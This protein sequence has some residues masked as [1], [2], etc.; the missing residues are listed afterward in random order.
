MKDPEHAHVLKSLRRK[1]EEW[2]YQTEDPLALSGRACQLGSFAIIRVI[3][4]N[5][6]S[7]L[8]DRMG[9]DADRPGN[10][11]SRAFPVHAQWGHD[12]N[13]VISDGKDS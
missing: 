3:I 12:V 6:A 8:Q 2:P 7:E 11:D 5:P 13:I 1:L 4:H 9:F 10:R